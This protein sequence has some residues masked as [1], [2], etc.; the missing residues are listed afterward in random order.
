MMLKRLREIYC[1][2]NG[3]SNEMTDVAEAYRR[4]ARECTDMAAR[5]TNPE[6]KA[7]WLNLAEAWLKLAGQL[8]GVLSDT[9]KRK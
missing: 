7:A 4:K 2:Q 3:G 8:T 9:A 6:D 5:I 1:R